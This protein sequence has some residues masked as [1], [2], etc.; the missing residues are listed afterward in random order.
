VTK[1]LEGQQPNRRRCTKDKAVSSVCLTIRI[2]MPTGDFLLDVKRAVLSG[3]RVAFLAT[4]EGAVS[5]TLC[6]GQHADRKRLCT[7]TDACLVSGKKL[8]RCVH[9]LVRY[10]GTCGRLCQFSSS[11]GGRPAN[12]SNWTVCVACQRTINSLTR[13]RTR[14]IAG[15]F[16]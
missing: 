15:R 6:I 4:A 11:K 16:S 14:L 7:L 2:S 9:Y 13:L 3:T 1:P 10:Q 12:R 8:K 5:K